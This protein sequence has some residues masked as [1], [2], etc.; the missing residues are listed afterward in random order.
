VSEQRVTDWKARVAAA[1]AADD[2]ARLLGEI[3]YASFLG[4]SFGRTDGQLVVHM[5]FSDHL[6]GDSTIP[7]LHGGTL[8]ALLESAAIFT[9]IWECD[10]LPRTINLTI[11]YLRSGRAR[12]TFA[13][14]TIVKRGRRVLNVR[15]TAWQEDRDKP[16]AMA[17]AHFLAR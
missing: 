12:E 4:L 11:D 5:P 1:R 17:D 8:G 14:A 3:P 9:A 10:C 15:A 16:I 13:S 6:V 2:P 7:A